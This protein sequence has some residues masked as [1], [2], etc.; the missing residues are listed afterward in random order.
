[1][2]AALIFDCKCF[3]DLQNIRLWLANQTG[4]K[5]AKLG[6]L[7]VPGKYAMAFCRQ[8]NC[9][10]VYRLS[11]IKGGNVPRLKDCQVGDELDQGVTAYA[12]K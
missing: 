1:M 7:A 8:R 11:D 2:Y 12:K 3:P 4:D 5:L 10:F 9:N 6:E